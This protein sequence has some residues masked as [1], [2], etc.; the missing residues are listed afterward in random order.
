[1]CGLSLTHLAE[2]DA[3]V[4][5]LTRVLR[6]G[7]SLVVSDAHPALVLLQGQALF[8]HDGG[9]A[10]IRNHVHLHSR[11]LAAFRGAGLAVLDCMEGTMQPEFDGDL[12]ERAARA[13][14]SILDDVPAVLVWRLERPR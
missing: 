4:H 5:E 9:F 13:T 1:V 11:Y 6:P 12:L 10:F 14:A 8:P 3:A 7:G 2:L